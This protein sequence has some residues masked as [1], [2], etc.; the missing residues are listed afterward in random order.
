MTDN[1]GHDDQ[2]RLPGQSEWPNDNT[3]APTESVPTGG[4][5]YLA[6]GEPVDQGQPGN[7]PAD[8][9][10]PYGFG[11]VEPD[12]GT[13]WD[14]TTETV[15]DQD[16]PLAKRNLIGYIVAGLA[17]L[18]VIGFVTWLAN[19]LYQAGGQEGAVTPLTEE[20]VPDEPEVILPT[21]KKVDLSGC[22]PDQLRVV[23]NKLVATGCARVTYGE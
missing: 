6:P 14:D 4:D 10:D 19:D 1:N 18:I 23:G 9:D 3:A 17:L 22:R 5:G 7:T 13:D 15:S 16:K 12:T 21:L 8:S 11:P 2:G 20:V